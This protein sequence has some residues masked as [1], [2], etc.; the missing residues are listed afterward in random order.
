MCKKRYFLQPE[1]MVAKSL[2]DNTKMLLMLIFSLGADQD[3][4]NED[5]E[6]LV[7]LQPEY[8]ALVSQNDITKYSYNPYLMEKAILVMSS[9]WIL[10]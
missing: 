3:V 6:N 10:I 1:L 4:V 7:Q 2:Q 9:R 8:G 5:H